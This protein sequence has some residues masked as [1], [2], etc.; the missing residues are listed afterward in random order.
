M[1]LTLQGVLAGE[2]EYHDIPLYEGLNKVDINCEWLKKEAI[3]SWHKR[4]VQVITETEVRVDVVKLDIDFHCKNCPTKN[5]GVKQMEYRFGW[6][7]DPTF[8]LYTDPFTLPGEG[9]YNISYRGVD[10]L[11]HIEP[12]HTTTIYV[13]GTPPPSP[14]VWHVHENDTSLHP[15]TGGEGCRFSWETEGDTSAILYDFVL[16]TDPSFTD[17]VV[18]EEILYTYVG[19]ANINVNV[20]NGNL[21]CDT[22]YYGRVNA[23]D[24]AGNIAEWT[25]TWSFHV[26]DSTSPDKP[27]KPVGP[28]RGKFGENYTYT[29]S[30]IDPE[31][32][33]VWYNF[34]WGDGTYSGWLGPYASEQEVTASHNWSEKGS[35]EV[36]VQAMDE[37]GAISEWSDPIPVTMPYVYLTLLERIIGWILQLF[38]IAIP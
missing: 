28:G 18:D 35:Y 2:D 23:T 17:I 8:H 25:K 34:S 20:A 11:G 12:T 10:N 30:T 33:I 16:T 9:W 27:E 7:S 24:L 32:E 26:A 21:Y 31:G 29:T 3:K 15:F 5:A 22:T 38:G 13:D 4:W 19:D 37:C 1:T 6:E 14:T 36:K